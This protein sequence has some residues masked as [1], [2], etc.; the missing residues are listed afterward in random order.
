MFSYERLMPVIVSILVQWHCLDGLDEP[1]NIVALVYFSQG[2][3]VLWVSYFL[4][5]ILTPKEKRS[6]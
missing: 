3:I 2:V 6:Q 4:I 5:D 1:Y